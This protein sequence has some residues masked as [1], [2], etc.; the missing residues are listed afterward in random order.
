MPTG[1]MPN[2]RS[3][4]TPTPVLEMRKKRAAR[5]SAARRSAEA[6]AARVAAKRAGRKRRSAS[7]RCPDNGGRPTIKSPK[8]GR[9]ILLEGQAFRDAV[10]DAGGNPAACKYIYE[11]SGLYQRSAPGS[12]ARD[13]VESKIAGIEARLAR[14][15]DPCESRANASARKRSAAEEAKKL[16][17]WADYIAAFEAQRENDALSDEYMALR[18]PLETAYEPLQAEYRDWVEGEKRAGRRIDD[19]KFKVS[20]ATRRRID[21]AWREYQAAL[22]SFKGRKYRNSKR[23]P[24]PKAAFES[25]ALYERVRKAALR[26]SP[27]ASPE[28]RSVGNI[29]LDAFNRRNKADFERILSAHSMAEFENAARALGGPYQSE[30][31]F[32]LTQKEAFDSGQGVQVAVGRRSAQPKKR[33]SMNYSPPKAFV[34]TLEAFED[35]LAAL[36]AKE[37]TREMRAFEAATN[38]K[39]R[40]DAEAALWQKYFSGVDALSSRHGCEPLR[41]AAKRADLKPLLK[42]AIDY[43]LGKFGKQ[44]CE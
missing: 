10:A 7:K 35:D 29:V 30:S 27:R 24:T 42:E 9:C 37:F 14:G 34:R 38:P 28:Y 26:P 4:N 12:D 5:A 2:A 6:R 36:N 3:P 40:K 17:K 16:K 18:A 19:A 13:Q 20:D 41:A 8:S 21:D 25:D 44:F 32:V 15:E 43:F 23:R 31:K 33:K 11:Y 1:P 22:K 39:D